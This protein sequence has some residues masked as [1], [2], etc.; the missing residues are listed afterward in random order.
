M[1]LL[2]MNLDTRTSSLTT[3]LNTIDDRAR[4]SA[5]RRRSTFRT[6]VG[7][8]PTGNWPIAQAW[9]TASAGQ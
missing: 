8:P 5:R 7:A 4:H 3:T 1:G 2:R 9:E 6:V